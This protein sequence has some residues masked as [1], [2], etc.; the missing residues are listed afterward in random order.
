MF[1]VF[2]TPVFFYVIQGFGES[3]W[4]SL[5]VRK[6]ASWLLGGVLGS[7]V[8]FILGKLGH[9]PP[10]WGPIVGAAVG[11]LLVLAV[12]DAHRRWWGDPGA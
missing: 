3:R 5:R 9:V 12:L 8:G 1:G 7:A 2:L 6:T 4:F 11:V 10:V